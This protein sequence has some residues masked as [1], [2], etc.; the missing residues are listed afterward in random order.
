[1]EPE[2][3]GARAP[4]GVTLAGRRPTVAAPQQ[5]SD[6]HG[7]QRPGQPAQSPSRHRGH[8]P[9]REQRISLPR[10]R[11]ATGTIQRRGEA[12]LGCSNRLRTSCRDDVSPA[13]VDGARLRSGQ[14][15]RRRAA[16]ASHARSGVPSA[17]WSRAGASSTASSIDE[18]SLL[19]PWPRCRR[20]ISR[21][22]DKHSPG[23]IPI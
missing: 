10:Q 20:R 13:V 21:A 23:Y 7:R 5:P 19:T 3:R 17:T 11:G 14:C 16:P 4:H 9:T 2:P 18:A 12:T 22:S 6:L 1:M 8:G 15:S